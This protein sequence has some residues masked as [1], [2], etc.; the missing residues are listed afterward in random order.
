M[1]ILVYNWRCWCNP[2]M[3]GAEIFTHE[4]TTRWAKAGHRVTLFT[5]AF[6]GC[7]KEETREEVKIIRSGGRFSVFFAAKKFYTNRFREEHF[8][9]IIDEINTRPFFAHTFIENN[10]PVVALIHQLARE[11]WFYET[12][13]PIDR[14]GHYLENRW[15][16]K[17]MAIPTV[18]VSNSTYM[19]LVAVGLKRL[20]IIPEGVN[21]EPLSQVPRKSKHP[22]IVYSGRLKKAKRPIHALKAFE[23][24]KAK[25]PDAELWIIG[26]GPIRR[27]LEKASCRGVRFYGELDNFERRKLI[28]Q[29]WVLVHP[30]V[31]EGWGLNVIEANALGVPTVAY[32]VPGLKDSIQDNITGFLVKSGDIQAM[33][34]KLLILLA[35]EKLRGKFSKNALEYSHNFSWDVTAQEFLQIAMTSANPK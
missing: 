14:I 8:D 34:D 3:G 15:L 27:K 5:A 23:K 35:D 4:L 7:K 19:D 2:E 32:S 11:Y 29:S 12:K 17:Y 1:K 31:R 9:L 24:V 30:G 33:A 16:Q 13:F 28:E 26:D 25:F 21:F 18:T 10:E 22:V 6:P 20:F